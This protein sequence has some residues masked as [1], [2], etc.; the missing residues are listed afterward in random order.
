[1]LLDE[2]VFLLLQTLSNFFSVLIIVIVVRGS[3]R[4][5]VLD[6]QALGFELFHNCLCLLFFFQQFE[7]NFLFI[8]QL[9]HRVELL[10]CFVKHGQHLVHL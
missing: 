8:T 6:S 5:R 7:T 9:A 1:M 2:F 3:L 4:I 10:D